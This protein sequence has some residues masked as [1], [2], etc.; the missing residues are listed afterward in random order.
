MRIPLDGNK[1]HDCSSDCKCI[2]SSRHWLSG[3]RW[4]DTA[5]WKRQTKQKIK[6]S[7]IIFNLCVHVKYSWL[8]SPS[9]DAPSL[10]LSLFFEV[11]SF[12]SLNIQHTRKQTRVI[13]LVS[14]LRHVNH[15]N[16]HSISFSLEHLGC[17]FHS[18][19]SSAFNWNWEKQCHLSPF[20]SIYIPQT[21]KSTE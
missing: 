16:H 17:F 1:R 9:I 21:I 4:S 7:F 8:L 18:T 2:I 13:N 15:L 11:S 10:S 14:P 19:S 20:C 5:G 12:P 6:Y 3:Y